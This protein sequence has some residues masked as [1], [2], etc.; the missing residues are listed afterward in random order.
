[1]MASMIVVGRGVS[2]RPRA[3]LKKRA[4]GTRLMLASES[5][6]WRLHGAPVASALRR[7]G[8]KTDVHLLP[9]GEKAK[10]WPA[11]ERLLRAMLKADLGRDSVLLALGGGS[12]TDAAGFAAAVY[13]RGIPWISVPTTLLGQV[14]GGIG[15]KTAIDLPEGKNL[16]GAFHQPLA[17]VCD[18]SFL[19]TLPGR[20]LAS[21][22][23]EVIKYGLALD[24]A[25]LTALRQDRLEPLVRRCAALK[26]RLVAVDERETKGR[27]ELL[28]FGHTIGHALETSAGGRLRHGEAVVCGM[29]AALRLS[30]LED[31]LASFPLP[32]TPLREASVMKAL[33]R[34]KKARG[35]RLRFVLLKAAGRPFVTDRV[36]ER[37][38]REAVRFI[39]KEL[40]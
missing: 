39:L 7:A 24:P 31:I 37:R 35:G 3:W 16:V 22:L 11:V 34:D 18:T 2:R 29:R 10:A 13:M 36:P 33:H 21:G 4:R 6:V 27:R 5:R 19:E 12:V 23:G 32:R 20:E 38:V 30:G 9:G 40:R 26:S 1:M 17:V 28:N 8:F 15:G 25:L 14:D